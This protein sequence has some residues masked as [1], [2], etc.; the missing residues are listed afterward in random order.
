MRT[1]PACLLYIT[2]ID[3]DNTG[4]NL[5]QAMNTERRPVKFDCDDYINDSIGN[6]LNY[7]TVYTD[8]I[9]KAASCSAIAMHPS[10]P[11]LP[12]DDATSHNEYRLQ[13]PGLDSILNS[14]DGLYMHW[15]ESVYV[16]NDNQHANY[17]EY[18]IHQILPEQASLHLSTSSTEPGTQ[19]A[20]SSG[21]YNYNIE[22]DTNHY[23]LL[24]SKEENAPSSTILPNKGV[25][26]ELV[27]DISTSPHTSCYNSDALPS[28]SPPK[29]NTVH[30][31]SLGAMATMGT[32]QFLQFKL[33]ILKD[34]KK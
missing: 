32:S 6:N 30:S 7:F 12:S 31:C 10:S 13:L 3:M 9:Y 11:I 1:S 34:T 22:G 8:M 28:S 27:S 26:L 33:P 18:N 29:K 17:N 15:N 14:S 2:N 23:S 21:H 4:S 20:S 16:S 19:S 5:N 24:E 25:N